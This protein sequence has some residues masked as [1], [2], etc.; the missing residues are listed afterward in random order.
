[1]G[2]LVA[3]HPDRLS[4]VLRRI[5]LFGGSFDPVHNGHVALAEAALSGVA[6]DQILWIPAGQAWQ[7][8]RALTAAEHRIAMLELAIAHEPRFRVERIEVR[9]AG[10]SYMLD[11]VTELQ[12]A[13]STLQA[14]WFLLIGQDQYARLSTWH[15][16]RSLAQKVTF[17][18]AAR[19]GIP[20]I[21]DPHL[22][23][24]PHRELVIPMP[25]VPVSSTTIRKR[26]AA[27]L[28]LTGMVPAAV[29]G[30]IAA[31]GLYPPDALS[32]N[33]TETTG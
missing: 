3:H 5:G 28:G 20:P 10:P 12:A 33:P 7:K 32:K 9:R 30:Y 2:Q 11:T 27:G 22:A 8:A 1:V 17:A 4:A 6:L 26:L 15:G 21:P 16:W 31:H 23:V 19:D 25:E 14:E 24:I 18:V 13:A 29:E